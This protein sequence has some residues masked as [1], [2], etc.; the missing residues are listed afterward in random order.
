M[1]APNVSSQTFQGAV[2]EGAEV[3]GKR[4]ILLMDVGDVSSRI[5]KVLATNLTKLGTLGGRLVHQHDSSV[6]ILHVR[7][8]ICRLFLTNLT[9]FLG[10]STVQ[11]WMILS[12]VIVQ[13]ADLLEHLIAVVAKD[14]TMSH[15]FMNP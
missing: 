9:A 10:F 6:M 7:F 1:A 11:S 3:A 12:H 5:L 13:S 8:D 15:S 14:L 4:P 2:V